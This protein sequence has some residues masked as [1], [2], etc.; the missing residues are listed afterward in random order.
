MSD[1]IKITRNKILPGVISTTVSASRGAIGDAAAAAVGQICPLALEISKEYPPGSHIH[2]DGLNNT[3][4]L[5]VWGY[6]KDGTDVIFHELPALTENVN[7]P[8]MISDC[9]PVRAYLLRASG[10]QVCLH[11]DA[12]FWVD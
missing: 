9:I 5:Y 3:Y 10:V 11:A 2:L 12:L 4:C 8:A 1:D 6:S 7:N